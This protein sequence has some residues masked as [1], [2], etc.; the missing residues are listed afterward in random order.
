MFTTSRYASR[1]TRELAKWFSGTLMH[2]Y[3]ARGK[4]KVSQF[5]ELSRKIGDE[6]IFIIKEKNG[7]P[8]LI[9]V[10][11]VYEDFKWKWTGSIGIFRTNKVFPIL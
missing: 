1:K 6:R 11:E 5:V 8:V 10:I 2:K 3:F 4:K 9:D 7:D